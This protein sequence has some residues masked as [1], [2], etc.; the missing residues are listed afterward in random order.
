MTTI[1]VIREFGRIDDKSRKTAE[2]IERRNPM[3]YETEYGADLLHWSDENLLDY[4]IHKLGFYKMFSL[5]NVISRYNAF[6]QYCVG[7]GYISVNPIA[8]S[9]CFTSLYLMNE[10]IEAGNVPYYTREFICNRCREQGENA[11]YFLSITL[12]IYEGFKDYKTLSQIRYTDVDFERGTVRGKPGLCLSEELRENYRLLHEME[13][14]QAGKRR[15]FFD[16]SEDWLIRR[17]VAN[18]K[19]RSESRNV[20]RIISNAVQKIGLEQSVL[21]DSGLMMRL[22]D[23]MGEEELLAHM[24]Y[25]DEISKWEKVNRNREMEKIFEELG[26]EISVKNFMYDYRIYALCLKHGLLA[27]KEGQGE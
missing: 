27:K 5:G 21:Y 20:M 14:Y 26:I 13:F 7:Q 6:Y 16:D 17:L 19:E 4:L 23:R 25:T 8:N 18:G 12:S 1:E 2:Y 15:Q 9:K 22:C 3:Q 24:L 11:P 10:I